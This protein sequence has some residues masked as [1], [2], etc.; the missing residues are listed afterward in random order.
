MERGM[1]HIGN[2]DDRVGVAV[3][4]DVDD[5]DEVVEHRWT[6]TGAL[7][8]CNKLRIATRVSCGNN[9]HRFVGSGSDSI[10]PIGVAYKRVHE[11]AVAILASFH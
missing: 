3:D 4:V 8:R 5:D 9:T 2:A 11:R 6:D 1:N 7:C 10:T